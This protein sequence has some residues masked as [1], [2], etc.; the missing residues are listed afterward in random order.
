VA[1]VVLDGIPPENLRFC[2]GLLKIKTI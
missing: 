2:F 1:L